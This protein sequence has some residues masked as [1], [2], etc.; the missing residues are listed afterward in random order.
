MKNMKC[1]VY[2]ISGKIVPECG[3]GVTAAFP[4]VYGLF[5]PI[6]GKKLLSKTPLIQAASAREGRAVK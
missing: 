4:C 1:V 3:P 6:L 2:L 5:L